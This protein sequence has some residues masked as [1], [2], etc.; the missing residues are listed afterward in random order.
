MLIILACSMCGSSN[1]SRQSLL[2]SNGYKRASS[3][4]ECRVSGY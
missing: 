2:L 3:S 4:A 1:G